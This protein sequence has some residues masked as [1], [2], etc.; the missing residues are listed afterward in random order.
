MKL[1]AG[2]EEEFLLR[3]VGL[4]GYQKGTSLGVG[5]SMFLSQFRISFL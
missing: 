5:L 3:A 4:G 2:A 1:V